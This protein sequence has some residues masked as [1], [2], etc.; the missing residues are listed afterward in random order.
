MNERQFRHLL[1]KYL[2]GECTPEEVALLH[3][4][5]DSFQEREAASASADGFEQ[6]R[7][8]RNIQQHT[9]RQRFRK[10]RSVTRR[11][12]V[13]AASVLLLL[14]L[15][16]G[17]YLAYKHQPTPEVAWE[18]RTTQKGQR[19]TVTLTDGTTVYLNADSHLSFPEHF[20]ANKRA[21]VLEG[22]AFFKVARQPKRPFVVASGKLT[23]TVLGTSFNIEAFADAPT[24]V[25]VATGRVKVGLLGD[26]GKQQEV[27]LQ[28]DQQ[29]FYDGS[30]SKRE[31]DAQQFTA[32]RHRVL[33]FD[34]VSLAEAVVVL[35]RWFDVSIEVE[36]D[37]L[38]AC[39]VNGKYV[40]ESLINILESFR[41]ILKI[42]YRTVEARK[43]ILMGQSCH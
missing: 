14:G 24:K 22:E 16:I 12:V 26:H 4:F 27:L 20:D 43:I 37:Q 25:T 18:E 33:R 31:V 35:E 17:S 41:H 1:N 39:Q 5:Y 32:W 10:N 34:R 6:E 3:R 42:E 40:N 15:G 36:N 7:I 23:T 30:L 28:P 11:W 2:R 9:R 21:V 29:A 8:H 13:M 38:L 19:A